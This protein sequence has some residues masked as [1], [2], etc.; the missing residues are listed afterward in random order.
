MLF[1][2]EVE[3]FFSICDLQVLDLTIDGKV[4]DPEGRYA[5]VFDG[6]EDATQG[7]RSVWCECFWQDDD[8][9]CSRICHHDD[10]R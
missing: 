5:E 8:A 7:Y 9:A 4:P 10:P 3:N 1:R 2:L 6:S